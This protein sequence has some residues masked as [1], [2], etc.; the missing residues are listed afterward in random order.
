VGTVDVGEHERD[1][2]AVVVRRHQRRSVG[3]VRELAQHDELTP[4]QARGER[5]DGGADR[6]DEVALARVEDDAGRRSW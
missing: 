5:V 6:L 2:V 3:H 4:V 1:P